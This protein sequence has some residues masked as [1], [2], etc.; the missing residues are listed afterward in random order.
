MKKTYS[1]KWN[2]SKQVRKQR[3][4]RM[5]APLH[6]KHKLM[7]ANLSETLREKHSVRSLPVRKDDEVRV[8]RGKYRGKSGKIKNVDLKKTRVTID[9]LQGTKK[10][11]TKVD[12][13]FHPSN[14]QITTL[15]MEDKIRLT[16]NAKETTE[17]TQTPENKKTTTTK[18]EKT[19]KT[20]SNKTG[21]TK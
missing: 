4:F 13:Y 5:N 2:S 14:L 12:V 10:D 9:K 15:N 17:K 1:A 6:T 7:S 3:K 21:E 20:Q 11:G 18:N 19:N 8:M 16:N